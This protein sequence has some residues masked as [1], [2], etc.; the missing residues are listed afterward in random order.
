MAR[1]YSGGATLTPEETASAE[2]IRKKRLGEDGC[3]QDRDPGAAPAAHRTSSVPEE[4]DPDLIE[5]MRGM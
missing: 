1:D 2:R 4:E 3:P 5:S